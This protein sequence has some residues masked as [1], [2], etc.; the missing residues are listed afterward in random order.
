MDRTRVD[1][2]L[3]LSVRKMV[4]EIIY[5]LKRERLLWLNRD[6]VY[7]TWSGTR[8]DGDLFLVGMGWG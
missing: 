3:F 2:G 6:G 7:S 5:K 8:V 1:E 4:E